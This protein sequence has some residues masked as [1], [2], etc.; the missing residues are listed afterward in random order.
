MARN[1]DASHRRVYRSL[2][3]ERPSREIVMVWNPYR[4][5]SRLIEAFKDELRNWA[6]THPNPIRK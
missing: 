3:G 5:Q 4:F 2:A 1:Y 6:R